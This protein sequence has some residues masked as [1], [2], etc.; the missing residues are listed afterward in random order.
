MYDMYISRNGNCNKKMAHKSAST[1][2]H[3]CGVAG[4][5]IDTVIIVTDVWRAY[6][7]RLSILDL[8]S[9]L[10]L[11]ID[12]SVTIL[13][14]KCNSFIGGNDVILGSVALYY[15]LRH[16]KCTIMYIELDISL[17]KIMK[18]SLRLSTFVL[19]VG[20][21]RYL[22]A[23][24]WGLIYE[25]FH[26][27]LLKNHWCPEEERTYNC[28]TTRKHLVFLSTYW[29]CCVQCI[30]RSINKSTFWWLQNPWHA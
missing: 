1:I 6:L 25:K 20:W 28:S 16:C 17:N 21:H 29:M 26:E 30:Y 24:A 13:L 7:S 10:A 18:I 19:H 4:L 12:W 14:Y 27:F 5:T 22:F 2:Q 8:K 9:L 15:L 23:F 11:S 3:H